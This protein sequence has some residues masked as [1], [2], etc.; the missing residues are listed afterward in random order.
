MAALIELENVCKVYGNEARTTA[1]ASATTSIRQGELVVILGPSGS[2]K[3]TL[4]NLIGGLDRPTSGRVRVNGVDLGTLSPGQLADFRRDTIGFVFQF[5]NLIPSL[6]ARENVQFAAD[7]SH[8]PE[9]VDAMLAA[10]GLAKRAH[11]FPAQLSGGEQQRVAIARALVKNPPV[12]L[13][14]EPTGAL[15]IETGKSILSLLT[16]R[17]HRDHQTVLIVT[18]DQ[19]LA[20]LATRLIRLRDGTIRADEIRSNPSS[21]AALAH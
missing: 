5:Y 10:I 13:C 12:L 15:D 11:Q 3:S 7:L 1:L 20:V 4:L 6:T 9:R 16:A 8:C 2:G 17:V 19:D 18:H 21:V 14:D